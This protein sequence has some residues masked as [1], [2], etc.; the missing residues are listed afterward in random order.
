[1][2]IIYSETERIT[3]N[4]S[5][6]RRQQSY[7]KNKCFSRVA[8]NFCSTEGPKIV[9]FYCRVIKCVSLPPADQ[10]DP[11]YDALVRKNVCNMQKIFIFPSC[12]IYYFLQRKDAIKCT[13]W[14][15]SRKVPFFPSRHEFGSFLCLYGGTKIGVFCS[16]GS[17]G[18]KAVFRE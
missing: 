12:I 18:T 11:F 15:A 6:R 9:F 10:T 8:H 7:K 14:P 13:L 4:L 5:K 3:L 2:M 1:M 16:L 17:S